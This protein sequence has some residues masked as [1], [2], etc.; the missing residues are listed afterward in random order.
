MA[1]SAW[2]AL[3][4]A[5][6]A[7]IIYVG[8]TIAAFGIEPWT[9]FLAT[10]LPQQFAVLH[11]TAFDPVTM[12]SPYFLFRGLSLSPAASYALQLVVTVLSLAA[13]YVALR[14]EADANIR[15]LMVAC[16]A[17]LA[18]R[19]CKLTNCRFSPRPPPPFVLV[20]RLAW[21]SAIVG[22]QR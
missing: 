10:T 8:A 9:L 5:A 15:I 3:A 13:L 20:T 6:L 7:A 18:A 4:V 12:I 21:R 14:R 22:S 11:G 17:L 2:R 16:A 1:L 19:I